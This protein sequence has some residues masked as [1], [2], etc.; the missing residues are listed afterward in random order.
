MNK[1][2]VHMR[3]KPGMF[4]QYDGKVDV[5]A[6]DDEQAIERAFRE[7]KRTAFPDYTRDMWRVYL[8]LRTS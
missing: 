5:Y 8:V 4:A 6:E 7:I 3:T 1:Y 2:E